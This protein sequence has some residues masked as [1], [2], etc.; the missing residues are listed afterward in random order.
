MRSLQGN[1]SQVLRWSLRSAISDATLYKCLWCFKKEHEDTVRE[2]KACISS[3]KD[4]VAELR[5][6]LSTTEIDDGSQK[7]WTDVVRKR[8]TAAQKKNSAGTETTKPNTADAPAPTA[9]VSHVREKKQKCRVAGVRRIWGTLKS[10]TTN[11]VSGT[12]RKLANVD[13]DLR[14]LRRLK[15]SGEKTQWWFVLKSEEE[16]LANL[17][18]EWNKIHLQTNWK[19]E[20][21]LKLVEQESCYATPAEPPSLQPELTSISTSPSQTSHTTTP[22]T[23]SPPS[24][25]THHPVP[26]PG[27]PHLTP[28]AHQPQA[29]IDIS[30]AI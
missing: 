15:K 25:P 6:R 18:K 28:E 29:H 16:T 21:C 4:E 19:I 1:F 26:T 3:L 7:K 10:T 17:E 22:I 11:A 23:A 27:D 5:S 14:V 20:P 12:I 13:K 30:S 2:L 9:K 24:S 8:R